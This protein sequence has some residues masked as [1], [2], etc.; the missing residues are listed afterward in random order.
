V[1]VDAA[2]VIQGVQYTIATAQRKY[3]L[4]KR[5]ERN[6]MR[7]ESDMPPFRT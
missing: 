7:K 5:S 6:F 2:D 1:R 3:D 4:K